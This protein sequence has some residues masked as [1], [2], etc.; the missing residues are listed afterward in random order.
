MWDHNKKGE[1]TGNC[2]TV[3]AI[4]SDTLRVSESG[5]VSVEFQCATL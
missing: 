1:V 2:I 4:V 3:C 5:I